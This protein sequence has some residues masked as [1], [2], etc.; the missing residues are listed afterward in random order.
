MQDDEDILRRLRDSGD[1]E[2]FGLLVDRHRAAVMRLALA[3]LGPR[4]AADAEDVAQE[5]FVR[6]WRG[7]P[8]FRGESAFATWLH[9][10]AWN[11][12]R[13]H[14]R[15]AARRPVAVAGEER[16][17]ASTAGEPPSER[18]VRAARARIVR[19]CVEELPGPYRVA[20]HLHYWLEAPVE[21]IAALLDVPSGTV[22]SYLSR[23][24]VR[25][26][27]LLRRRGVDR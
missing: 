16:A 3:V 10:I 8:A 19:G 5:V 18:L 24:R 23:G 13:D 6:A 17:E 2:L 26:D 4:H 25:V 22:K 1:P 7:L 14:R 21:E 11:L 12:A 27:R 9:R 20:L 15:G